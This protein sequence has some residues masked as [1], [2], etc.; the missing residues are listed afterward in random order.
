[1]AQRFLE[2]DSLR[3]LAALSV[4]SHHLVLALPLAF[5]LHGVAP[6][7]NG[8]E[9]VLLFF[10]L[11]GFVL[12]LP[13]LEPPEQ[14]GVDYWRFCL[15]RL[16]R[17]YLPYLVAISI[18]CVGMAIW[19]HQRVDGLSAWFNTAWQGPSA[20]AAWRTH[21]DLLSNSAIGSLDPVVW[22]LVIELRVS[23][24]FPML[25]YVVNRLNWAWVMGLAIAS[26][27]A[28]CLMGA[29]THVSHGMA[30]ELART[31]HYL[32]MFM[33]GM[34]LARYRLQLIKAFQ[35]LTRWQRWAYTGVGLMGYYAHQGLL[36]GH[37]PFLEDW[38]IVVSVAMLVIGVLGSPTVAAALRKPALLRLGTISYSLYLCHVLVLL[39][40]V[41]AAHGYLPLPWLVAAVVPLSL[42]VA[43]LAYRFVER[44]A[45][46]LGRKLSSLRGVLPTAEVS[47]L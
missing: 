42:W 17:I 40:L 35:A 41:H 37:F 12:N 47:V 32:P 27:I 19:G 13:F 22:S 20:F 5:V 4:V 1:M 31:C 10:V 25:A 39:V 21:L 18:G 46:A 24:V 6:V 2:L 45:M 44:P 43:W 28:A 30:F 26:D 38:L 34:L 8:Y 15:K 7:A 29:C 14:G 16:C 9:A 11:S 23:L 36:D 33:V 3:G